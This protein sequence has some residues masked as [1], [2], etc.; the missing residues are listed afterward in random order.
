MLSYGIKHAQ[1]KDYNQLT[2][3]MTFEEMH[4]EQP[5]SLLSQALEGSERSDPIYQGVEVT[6]SAKSNETNKQ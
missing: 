3:M 2:P 5:R 4:K 1:D 6:L